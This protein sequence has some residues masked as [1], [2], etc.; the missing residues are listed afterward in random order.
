MFGSL[1]FVL[2]V[3]SSQ[4]G[5][6]VLARRSSWTHPP[7]APLLPTLQTWTFSHSSV[8]SEPRAMDLPS[9]PSPRIW[10]L[11]HAQFWRDA[12]HFT[13]TWPCCCYVPDRAACIPFYP[14]SGQ[15]TAMLALDLDAVL[16]TSGFLRKTS[17]I[18]LLICTAC[19]FA[20]KSTSSQLSPFPFEMSLLRKTPCASPI[21]NP[22]IFKES[23]ALINF[24]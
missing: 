4:A 16:V 9:R 6:W 10:F 1:T 8:E 17:S 3:H 24:P 18:S 20:S 15:V 11:R 19:T 5:L 14:S 2:K 22:Q 13:Q 23:A 21:G 7:R 12:K